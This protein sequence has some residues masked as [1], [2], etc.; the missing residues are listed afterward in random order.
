MQSTALKR[1]KTIFRSALSHVSDIF[2]H[3]C[4]Y[5]LFYTFHHMCTCGPQQAEFLET[6]K[7]PLSIEVYILAIATCS[8]QLNTI[9]NHCQYH[10]LT[11][12]NEDKAMYFMTL[13]S[14]IVI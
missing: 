7:S 8:K 9:E 3:I 1:E 13:S 6:Y 10:I 5:D 11:Q 14:Q 4:S 2:P 12:K